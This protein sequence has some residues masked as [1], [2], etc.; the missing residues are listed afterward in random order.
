M[1][2]SPPRPVRF[3]DDGLLIIAEA[4]GNHNGDLKNAM[5]MVEAAKAAGADA[6]KFQTW[7]TEQVYS[8]ADSIK[9]DYQLAGTDPKESEFHTVKRN[10]LSF[11]A[12]R[13]LKKHCAKVGIAMLSTPDEWRSADFLTRELDLPVVKIA[14]QDVN[15]L[16]FLRYLAAT[17]KPLIYS[18]GTASLAEV[19]AAVDAMR[20]AGCRELAVLH[21]TSC[22]PA[23]AKTLNLRAIVTLREALRLPVGYSDHSLGIEMGGAAVA[24]GACILEKHFTLSRRLPGP[25]QAASL[26]PSELKEYI[27]SARRVKAALGDGVKA[28]RPEE[29]DNR[30]AMRRFLAAGRD[31]PAGPEHHDL[32]VGARLRRALRQGERVRLAELDFTPEAG[33]GGKTPR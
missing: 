3:D 4:G 12:F 6:V 27:D 30:L 24:L 8:V 32:V 9:P 26:E 23:A 7:I 10:E 21:C 13:K 18:S 1:R 19:A 25:D 2:A 17:G 22:Y 15:N 14:S 16:P 28:M 11:D 29:A 5:E 31:L 33:F 20:G